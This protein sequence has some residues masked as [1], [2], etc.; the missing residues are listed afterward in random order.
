MIGM[1]DEF[2]RMLDAPGDL[3]NATE[4]RHESEVAATAERRQVQYKIGNPRVASGRKEI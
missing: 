4:S 3:E 2:E 1:S